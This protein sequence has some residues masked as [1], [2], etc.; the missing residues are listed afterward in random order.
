MFD[1]FTAVAPKLSYLHSSCNI[2]ADLNAANVNLCIFY[3]S[4]KIAKIIF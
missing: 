2:L 1:D 4:R 3:C